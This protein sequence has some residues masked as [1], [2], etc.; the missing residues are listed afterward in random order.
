MNTNQ[1]QGVRIGDE[2]HVTVTEPDRKSTSV[3][4]EVYEGVVVAVGNAQRDPSFDRLVLRTASG[5]TLNWYFD[6][7]QITL[8]ARDGK[9]LP[10]S[11]GVYRF[12]K[13]VP[14]G[15]DDDIVQ[16]ADDGTFWPHPYLFSG[17][18]RGELLTYDSWELL[19]DETLDVPPADD[20]DPG[21]VDRRFSI[22]ERIAEVAPEMDE[23][24]AERIARA[25]STEGW[26][27]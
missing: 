26:H 12:R 22:L 5:Q 18:R 15:H 20:R 17:W 25:L 6:E 8:L 2:L 4:G 27:V 19:A 10:T 1:V 3:V 23:A 14:G 21:V 9:T 11:P 13:L 24:V 7:I 16:L